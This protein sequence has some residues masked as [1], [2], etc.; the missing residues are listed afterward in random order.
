MKVKAYAIKATRKN[1]LVLNKEIP[2]INKLGICTFWYIA[3]TN[4][5]S[6]QKTKLK[7]I[8]D[9]M[10]FKIYQSFLILIIFFS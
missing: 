2:T 8:P 3:K 6:M 7:C 5:A 1:R 4:V 10:A 9:C